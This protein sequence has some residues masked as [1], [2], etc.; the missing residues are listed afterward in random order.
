MPCVSAATIQK[1]SHLSSTN[2]R[3]ASSNSPTTYIPGRNFE[4]KQVARRQARVAA[5]AR[6]TLKQVE[7][8]TNTASPIRTCAVNESADSVMLIDFNHG[9]LVSI[10]S[11]FGLRRGLVR[12]YV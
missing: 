12:D 3:A 11:T 6:P 4:E 5:A 7:P 1:L 2:L 8:P 10:V 9:E